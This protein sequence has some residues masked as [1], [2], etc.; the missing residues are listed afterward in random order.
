M[1]LKNFKLQEKNK[2][3]C[4]IITRKAFKAQKENKFKNEIID[5]KI[6]SKNTE[7]NFNVDEHPREGIN[8]ETLKKLKPV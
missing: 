6:K 8:L 4:F 2:I 1:L 3:N 7:I 5:F